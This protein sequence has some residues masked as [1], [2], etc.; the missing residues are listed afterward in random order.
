MYCN[1]K[2]D[3]QSWPDGKRPVTMIPVPNVAPV[4]HVIRHCGFRDAP[5]QAIYSHLRRGAANCHKTRLLLNPKLSWLKTKM[6][7]FCPKNIGSTDY[8]NIRILIK[9]LAYTNTNID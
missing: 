4:V 6:V 1:A 2:L 7:H 3:S 5:G 9:R 8:M